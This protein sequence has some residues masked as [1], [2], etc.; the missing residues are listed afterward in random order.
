[1]D[2]SVNGPLWYARKIKNDEQ[3]ELNFEEIKFMRPECVILLLAISKMLYNQTGC[4]VK[5]ENLTQEAKSYL[6]RIN[7]SQIEFIQVPPPEHKWF[8]SPKPSMGLSE[9]QRIDDVSEL[10]YL[11]NRTTEILT[12]WFPERAES[13]TFCSDASTIIM[14]IVNNS[15]EHSVIDF[16]TCPGQCYFTIQKYQAHNNRPTV[17]IAFGDLGIGI[18]SS[19]QRNNNWVINSDLY[20]IKK[21]LFEGG[22][23]GRDSRQGGLGLPRIVS[24]LRDNGGCITIRSGKG[25]IFYRPKTEEKKLIEHKELLIGTQ[26][27][28]VF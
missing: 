19:L 16:N 6:E 14:E 21:V 13:S 23:T 4:T 5:W 10:T 8:R 15:I 27:S 1:M 25:S 18:K 3:Y 11:M 24:L 2:S 9:L 12:Q 22:I 28:I 7:I 20:A 26:T 17:V